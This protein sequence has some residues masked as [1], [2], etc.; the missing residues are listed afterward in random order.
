[1]SP[2]RFRLA[3][4]LA[5]VLAVFA[6]C[7]GTA[8]ADDGLLLPVIPQ[9][10]TTP[11]PGYSLSGRDALRRAIATPVVQREATRG[12]GLTARPF[13]FG[14]HDWQVSFYRRGREVVRVE[15]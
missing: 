3:A 13:L 8:A 12:P 6:A 9:S 7:A 15:L 1:M 10:L 14:A 2:V 5:V 4:A 11:P